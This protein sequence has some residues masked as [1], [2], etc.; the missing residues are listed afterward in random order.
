MRFNEIFL[1]GAFIV[2]IEPFGDDRGMFARS[3]CSREFMQ[4]GLPDTFVQ[5]NISVNRKKGTL[6]GMHYQEIPYGEAKLVRC[7]R[8]AIY[9][10]IVDL[11]PESETLF[12]WFSVILDE[13]NRR[14]LFIP[15]GFAH[16][17]QTLTD[18]A[19]VFY[20]MSEFYQPEFARGVRWNDP[21]FEIE[22]PEDTRI[23]SEKDLAYPDFQP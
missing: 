3:W 13:N 5:C 10:V 15:E 14:S 2:D 21:L 18:N 23:I 11:R 9:D 22:W 8:G 20:Q 4:N 19:E 6:R 17:F 12:K 1:K 16:G 7:T